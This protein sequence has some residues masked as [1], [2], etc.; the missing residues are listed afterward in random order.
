MTV[1]DEG[2]RFSPDKIK[3]QARDLQEIGLINIKQWVTTMEGTISIDIP[4][5]GTVT[6]P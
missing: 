4:L 6:T 5:T 2:R 1:D 3:D